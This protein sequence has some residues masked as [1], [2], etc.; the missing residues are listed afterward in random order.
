VRAERETERHRQRDRYRQRDRETERQIQTQSTETRSKEHRAQTHRAQS[1]EH[2]HSMQFVALLSG[3]KDSCYNVVKCISHGHTLICLANLHPPETFLGEEMDS[4]MYQSAAH[5]IIPTQAECFGVPLIR[6]AI[7]GAAV[8]QGLDYL[9]P[10]E[11][12]EVGDLLICVLNPLP[13]Y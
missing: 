3:G 9:Q 10:Q 5:N 8:N 2:T 11:D 12:D 4:F 7:T 1:T 6:Q 13:L